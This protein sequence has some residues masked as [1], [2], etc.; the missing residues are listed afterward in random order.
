MRKE[1]TYKSDETKARE[2]AHQFGQ[3]NGN[4]QGDGSIAVN[5]REFYKWVEQSATLEE[6]NAYADDETKPA[7]RRNFVRAMLSAKSVAEHFALTNQVHGLPK[8]SIEVDNKPTQLT[9][10]TSK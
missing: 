4:K 10:K 9:I 7:I 6:L 3:P 5:Q 2:R 1:R 8:Q